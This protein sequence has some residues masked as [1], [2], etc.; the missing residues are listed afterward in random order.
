[1]HFQPPIDV[2]RFVTMSQLAMSALVKAR[3][4]FV[5]FISFYFCHES[6]CSQYRINKLLDLNLLDISIM[7]V[8]PKIDH[9]IISARI[10][11]D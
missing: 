6:V 9:I 7:F 10:L 4:Q 2:V 11:K 5:L 8:P 1:M 3:F